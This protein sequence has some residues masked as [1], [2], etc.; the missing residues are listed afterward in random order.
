MPPLMVEVESVQSPV[1]TL[2]P[3]PTRSRDDRRFQSSVMAR[4]A[5]S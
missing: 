2:M 1:S 5:V 3:S 4:F